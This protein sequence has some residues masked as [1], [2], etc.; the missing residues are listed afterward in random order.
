M[1]YIYNNIGTL[2]KYHINIDIIGFQALLL[3]SWD[4]I[5]FEHLLGYK[6]SHFTGLYFIAIHVY[7]CITIVILQLENV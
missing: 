7:G 4:L 6:A 5:I 3:F 2:T 1:V